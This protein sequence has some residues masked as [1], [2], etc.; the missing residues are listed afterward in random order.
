MQVCDR[1]DAG[2]N[3]RTP[4]SEFGCW[5]LTESY[6]RLERFSYVSG[7]DTAGA[8]LDGG[9]AAISD[10]LDFLKIGIPNGAGLVVCVADIV[11]EAGTFSAYFTFS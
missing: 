2:K 4:A 5:M 7:A 1:H 3:S 9:Y 11:A 6:K 10:G 8:D